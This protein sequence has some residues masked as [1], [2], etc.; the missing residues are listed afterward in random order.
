MQIGL[1]EQCKVVLHRKD[2]HNERNHHFLPDRQPVASMILVGI[3]IL[4][5][6]HVSAQ[7]VSIEL[8]PGE[9]GL[10]EQYS[11]SIVVKN[12]R[13][14]NYDNFPEING[15]TK[16][17]TSTSSSTNI[18][19]G[20]ISS[21]NSVV[22][23]YQPNQ[24]GLF[25]IPSFSMTVNG[26]TISSP[27]GEVRV[28]P[29]KQRSQQPFSYDPFEEFFGGSREPQEY[30]DVQED[31]FFALT[32]DKSN[33][34][35]GE[36]FV[37]TIAF[38]EAET[39][40]AQMQFYELSKQIEEILK[41]IK[42][43]NCWEENFLIENIT[44]TPVVVNGKRY[45]QYRL[46]QAT[47]YPLNQEDIYFPAIDFQMVKYKV[48]KNPTFFGHNRKGELIAFKSQPKSVKVRD[49]PPHPLKDRAAVGV[50]RLEESINGR[51]IETGSSFNYSFTI[52]GEGNISAINNP[53][54]AL[55]KDFDFYPP[56]V[57]QDINR[58]SGHVTGSKSFEYYAIP[59]EPGTY[60]LGNYIHWIYFN[61]VRHQYDTLRS[62]ISIEVTGESK[63]NQSI[64]ATDVGTFYEVIQAKSNVL[65]SRD[66]GGMVKIFVNIFI[67]LMLALAF[68]ILIKK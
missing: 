34:Y 20:R 4:T 65:T 64:A 52:T 27:G 19:N 44:G 1:I 48:A 3:F 68:L 46:Y 58:S 60:K 6:L 42:P 57:R 63:T 5:G 32:T 31:A 61:P 62:G 24:E 45:R 7:D 16:L 56:N 43:T 15:F 38:Y 11:V 50:Y 23:A 18:V 25:H 67:F 29:P 59:N 9:I 30:V 66:S 35:V 55:K 33:V 54:I 41:K 36:G 21:T 8:G 2:S 17:G 47:L 49:L 10:N 51:K 12:E 14:K 13:I 39:N 40:K 28:G 37:V 53:E 22:Q 26:R